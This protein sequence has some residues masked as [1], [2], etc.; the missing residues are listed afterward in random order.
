MNRHVK[1]AWKDLDIL[2]KRF[3]QQARILTKKAHVG[4]DIG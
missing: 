1:P 3:W 2:R 4:Y